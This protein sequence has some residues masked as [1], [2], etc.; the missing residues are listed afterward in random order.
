MKIEQ[1][2]VRAGLASPWTSG[3][4]GT[5][6]PGVVR[7]LAGD[8]HLPLSA[9]VRQGVAQEN[10]AAAGS[11]THGGSVSATVSE[12]AR[13]LGAQ[14]GAQLGQPVARVAAVPVRKEARVTRSPALSST[15]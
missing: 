5:A 15:G 8:G 12:F 9:P 13:I 14:L 1:H 3:P 10:T 2:A 7:V 4:P 6:R 11:T